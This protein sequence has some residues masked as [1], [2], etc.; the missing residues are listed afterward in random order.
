M[1]EARQSW[2]VSEQ[3][4]V[5]R[6]PSLPYAHN[7]SRC[8]HATLFVEGDWDGVAGRRF[9]ESLTD[10]QFLT[11]WYHQLANWK[12]VALAAVQLFRE[13]QTESMS[14][15]DAALAKVSLRSRIFGKSSGS[16]TTP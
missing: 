15:L 11:C 12:V 9:F 6:V 7:P 1:E 5:V 16:S 4:R 14:K 10:A 8:S 2:L 3:F 13:V